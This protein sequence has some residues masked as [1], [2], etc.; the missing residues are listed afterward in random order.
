M[1]IEAFLCICQMK[2]INKLRLKSIYSRDLE[3]NHLI[4][5]AK[6]LPE[7]EEISF[8]KCSIKVNANSLKLLISSANM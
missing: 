7:L 4:E 3:E 1:D 5:W 8:D 2:Q 6:Q